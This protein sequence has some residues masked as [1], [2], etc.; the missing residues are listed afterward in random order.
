LNDKKVWTYIKADKEKKSRIAD[1]IFFDENLQATHI[2]QHPPLKECLELRWPS[3]HLLIGAK[4]SIRPRTKNKEKE[5][6]D[7][8]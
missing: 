8:K 5:Q 4:I 2:I 1:Y 6:K 7:V 3:N